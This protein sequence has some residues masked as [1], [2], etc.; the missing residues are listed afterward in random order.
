MR[1]KERK[2]FDGEAGRVD[3]ELSTLRT[4]LDEFTVEG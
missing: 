2:G 4:I 3:D 1:E